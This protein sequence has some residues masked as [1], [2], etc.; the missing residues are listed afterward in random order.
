VDISDEQRHTDATIIGAGG[1]NNSMEDAILATLLRLEAALYLQASLKQRLQNRAGA[2]G[3]GTTT[4]KELLLCPDV[5]DI[6][7]RQQTTNASSGANGGVGMAYL[8]S[9]L[10]AAP[11]TSTT[12]EKHKQRIQSL[13]LKEPHE[14]SYFMW[15]LLLCTMA[16]ELYRIHTTSS[17]NDASPVLQ[18]LDLPTN[19]TKVSAGGNISNSSSKSKKAAA[20]TTT[21]RLELLRQCYKVAVTA[22]TVESDGA[23]NQKDGDGAQSGGNNSSTAL[24]LDTLIPVLE[25]V[26]E[27]KNK[28]TDAQQEKSQPQL[29]DE[30]AGTRSKKYR[31]PAAVQGLI[32]LRQQSSRVERDLMTLDPEAAKRLNEAEAKEKMTVANNKISKG[33]S[34][35]FS[36][37]EPFITKGMTLEQRVRAR[38]EERQKRQQEW[39]ARRKQ[40]ANTTTA[41]RQSG[42]DANNNNDK[43]KDPEGGD[44]HGMTTTKSSSGTSMPPRPTSQHVQSHLIP[45]ADALWSYL[46]QKHSRL[47]FV[48]N[49]LLRTSYGNSGAS[50]IKKKQSLAKNGGR[51]A[52]APARPTKSIQMSATLGELMDQLQGGHG[53]G[54]NVATTHRHN[55]K[56]ASQKLIR[57][58]L[59]SLSKSCPEWIHVKHLHSS[60]SPIPAAKNETKSASKAHNNEEEK[61]TKLKWSKT[62]V[63]RISSD[64][65]PYQATRIQLGATPPATVR[66]VSRD[67]GEGDG[68]TKA[69]MKRKRDGDDDT[70][71]CNGSG[72]NPGPNGSKTGQMKGER[73]SQTS[74]SNGMVQKSGNGSKSTSGSEKDHQAQ[75]S[76][77]ETSSKGKDGRS[78]CI[79]DTNELLTAFSGELLSPG[80][81]KIPNPSFALSKCSDADDAATECPIPSFGISTSSPEKKT[82]TVK[83]P[84]SKVLWSAPSSAASTP[85]SAHEKSKAAGET[86]HNHVVVVFHKRPKV[87][88]TVGRSSNFTNSSMALTENRTSIS[89]QQNHV[90]TPPRSKKRK[91]RTSHSILP[92]QSLDATMN[93]ETTAHRMS[94]CKTT[95]SSIIGTSNKVVYDV[96]P[97]TSEESFKAKAPK[98]RIN[99]HLVFEHHDRDTSMASSFDDTKRSSSGGS[100]YSYGSNGEDTRSLKR[101]FSRMNAGERV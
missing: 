22:A 21:S 77:S 10:P 93:E 39:T 29:T 95:T 58:Q 64:P 98:L 70:N 54:L 53:I 62:T 12:M 76:G 31:N 32:G 30:T 18:L 60:N 92:G 33:S 65:A 84:S 23:K 8:L 90:P 14:H 72:S 74:G 25:S 81:T 20:P 67:E 79:D 7:V 24:L 1:S 78:S 6:I 36:S 9:L 34:V 56:Y 87:R 97:C 61:T 101:L 35:L 63:L 4:K 83:D 91:N 42:N 11:S 44:A 85:Q 5:E 89:Q 13:L 57:R 2:G 73:S 41:R 27:N 80:A 45:I 26:I 49:S 68:A 100:S 3:V 50:R 40:P 46:R 71:S 59:K 82:E 48:E 16:P 86:K 47:L 99:P 17:S 52:G 43:D 94:P 69:M 55:Q 96:T 38:A 66:R 15:V 37:D 88:S 51:P 28:N 75:H 19:N